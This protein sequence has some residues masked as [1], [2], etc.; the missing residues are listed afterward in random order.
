MRT[1]RRAAATRSELGIGMLGHGFMGRAHSR[2]LT[3]L[4]VIEANAP[5]RPRLVSVSGRDLRRAQASDER[6]RIFD[7]VSPNGSHLEPTLAAIESGKHLFCEKP[8]GRTAAEARRLWLEADRRGVAHMCG[9]NL[10]FVPAIR[11][12]RELLADGELA[13]PTHFRG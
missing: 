12:A 9:F 3:T 1:A 6:V 4:A 8:L 11:R 2:A 7:N 5:A 10:R 13:E